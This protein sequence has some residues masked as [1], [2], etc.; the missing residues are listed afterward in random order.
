MLQSIEEVSLLLSWGENSF[1]MA[2]TAK[3]L[4]ISYPLFGS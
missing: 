4:P 2:G 3:Y 1:K